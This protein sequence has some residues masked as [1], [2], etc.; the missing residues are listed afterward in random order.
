M[1][2]CIWVVDDHGAVGCGRKGGM[3][4]WHREFGL[5]REQMRRDKG[6][7]WISRFY[8]SFHYHKQD[9]QLGVLAHASALQA[10]AIGSL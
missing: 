2:C 3:D 10:E 7:R 5:A 6:K 9:N 1:L 8:F 4:R